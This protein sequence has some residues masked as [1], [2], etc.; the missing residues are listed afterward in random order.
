MNASE[1][2][3]LAKE[4]MTR[5]VLIARDD[6]SLNGLKTFLLE[7]TI[8]GAPVVD[9]RGAL[10]GVV[11]ATDLL[12]SEAEAESSIETAPEEAGYYS[13]S[14][15]R[16]LSAEELD[17]VLIESRSSTLVRDVMTPVVFQVDAETELDDVADLMV[18]GRIHRVIVTRDGVVT[19]TG[20]P[21]HV[22]RSTQV[23]EVRI[24]DE[25]QR[26]ICVSRCTLA[27]V[28]KDRA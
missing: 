4:V 7:N 2:I 23:W 20:S 18:R 17:G 21:I 28:P 5:V 19:G 1:V 16:P 12:R 27:V 10:I 13:S 22:G 26:V 25:Q 9:G 15:E 11:S 3:V 8:S 14:L 24:V 6:W